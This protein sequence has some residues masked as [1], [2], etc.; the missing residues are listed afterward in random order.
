MCHCIQVNV[1]V[2][3]LFNLYIQLFPLGHL[4][5]LLLLGNFVHFIYQMLRIQLHCGRTTVLILCGMGLLP[6]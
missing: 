2:E 3:R 1:S 6:F 5:Q 4:F